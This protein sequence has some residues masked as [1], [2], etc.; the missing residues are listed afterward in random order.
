[1][2]TLYEISEKYQQLLELIADGEIPEEAIADTKEAVKGEFESKV[3]NIACYIKNLLSDASAIKEEADNLL[4]REKAL[5]NK[6]E[7][8]KKYLSNILLTQNILKVETPRNKVSFRA[9]EAVEISDGFIE[10]AKS[11]NKNLLLYKEPEPDKKA[12]KLYLASKKLKY[13]KII[14]K[15]N[16]QI[17]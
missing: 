2:A 13:A 7:S 10:W 17:K 3:D 1:M 9:S 16:I 14:N 6:A 4:E 11:K 12:I 5:K 8:L 15:Q